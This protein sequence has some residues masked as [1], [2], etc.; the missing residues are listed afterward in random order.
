MKKLILLFGIFTLVFPL[1]AQAQKDAAEE[2]V[3]EA[4]TAF[5]TLDQSNLWTNNF[6]QEEIQTLPVGIKYTFG[7]GS[8][9]NIQA[10]IGV[11]KAVMYSDYAEITVF[12]RVRLPQTDAT[13]KPLELFFGADKVKLSYQG[14]IIGDIKLALLGDINIPFNAGKWLLTLKGGFDYKTGV[15]QGLTFATI[16]CDGIKNLAIAGSVEFSR[17]MIIPVEANGEIDEKKTTVT[18]SQ[19]TETGVYT[20]Q[21]P[22]RVRGDFQTIVEDWNDI[23]VDIDMPQSFVLAQKMNGVDYEDNFVLSI[24]H[25]VLDMS[26]LRNSPNVQ[27]PQYYTDNGLLLPSV[28]AW[29]G[30]YVQS[31]EVGMPKKFM[32]AATA[33]NGKRVT[34]GSNDLIID[35]YGV[36]GYFYADSLI[37]IAEGITNDQKSWAY[38][39]DHIAVN[40]AAN[41]LIGMD[42]NGSI[43]LPVSNSDSDGKKPLGLKYTGLF[44]GKEYL[45]AVKTDSVI[46]FN[47]WKAKGQLLPN[48]YVEMR[49]K[50]RQ[51]RPKAVLNGFLSIQASNKDTDGNGKE[52]KPLVEFSRIEFQGL[53]MQTEAPVFKVDYMG[54]KKGQNEENKVSNFPVTID[55]IGITANDYQANLYLGVAINLMDGSGGFSGRTKVS[56]LG[57]FQDDNN[58][59]QKW[60]FKGV[61][62]AAVDLS[63]KLGTVELNGS[64]KM[65]EDDP[66]YGDGFNARLNGK[67]GIIG[68][69]ACNAIFGNNGFRYWMVDASISGLNIGTGAFNLDGFTGGASYHMLRKAGAGSSSIAPSGLS[70]VPDAGTGLGVKAMVSMSIGNKNAIVGKAGFEIIFNNSGGVNQMG[71]YGEAQMM[72]GLSD[73]PG[74]NKLADLNDKLQ[75]ATKKIQQQIPE[76]IAK[77]VGE[78]YIGKNF[79][80]M[81]KEDYPSPSVGNGAIS[82][83]LGMQQDFV[84]NVFHAELEIYVNIGGVLVGR[85]PNYRA[86]HGVVH[87]APGEWYAYLGRPSDRAG[88]K[89]GIGPLSVNVGGYFMVGDRLEA[90]PPPP[91]VVAQILGVDAESLNYM[92]D[93]NALNS[94]RGFAFGIDFG[95]DTGDL[96]FL[97][98]YARFQ[99]GGGFDIMLRDY[100]GAI[101]S[102]TGKA[103]GIN[104]WYA[105]G[106]A[107][108]YL[109][110]ELGIQVKLFFVN[111]KVPIISAGAAVLLQAKAPNPIWMRGY[112]GGYYNVLGGLLKGNF[113]FKLTL[114][115]EC[116]FAEISPIGGIKIISDVS[117]DNNSETDVFA[118]P[119]ATFAMKVGENVI[120]PEDSGDKTYKITLDKFRILDPQ[121]KAIEGTVEWNENKDAAN[122]ISK[123]ILPPNTRLKAEV[124]VSFMEKVNGVFRP[125]TVDGKQAI[126]SETREFT[127]GGA[128]DVI[129]LQNIQYAYPVLDQKYFFTDEYKNGYI[130]LKRGQSYLFDDNQ[131]A[132]V[133][134]VTDKGGNSQSVAFS[135]NTADSRIDYLLPKMA[136]SNSYHLSIVSRLKNA[137]TK[138]DNGKQE[139]NYVAQETGDSENT[140]LVQQNKAQLLSQDGEIERLVYDFSTSQYKSLKDKAGSISVSGYNFGKIYSDVIYLTNKIKDHEDFDCV[141]L[142]GN[143]YTENFPTVT[144]EAVLDD[145][146]F[147]K[148]INP[149]LYGRQ[150]LGGAYS[151]K[152]RDKAEYGIPPAKALPLSGSYLTYTQYGI[153]KEWTRT[154][155]PFDYQLPYFYKL[156]WTDLQSQIINDYVRGILPGNSPVMQLLDAGYKFIRQGYYNVRLQ[157][158][159]PGGTKGTEAIM[160]YKNSIGL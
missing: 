128:P 137:N 62:L 133:L 51:F 17:E 58:Y 151:L 81:A 57:A 150:A 104:G 4:K 66:V 119:Q 131:W 69:I 78:N 155:F 149:V 122:F 127:T 24:K 96:R 95:L 110:G 117:P 55:E 74:M 25:A 39:V 8:G 142:T 21:V 38:S 50:E 32:T 109:Q 46:D 83:F 29:R 12:A 125:V 76:N 102:N 146:Y 14:G 124:Q 2:S 113:R 72:A 126:G 22:Y 52:K 100:A 115:E 130:R 37:Q 42:F 108:A 141:E 105:N 159:L 153:N 139:E 156:D 123:E 64:L 15:T 136:Q 43:V 103:P 26:D 93:E 154:T 85:G 53:T 70:Y 54:Y 61:D 11:T 114:G 3:S 5:Q 120:I 67:F 79:L 13:G 144:V 40:L 88:L 87:I 158:I 152:L 19:Q 16:N 71:F 89:A 92:R 129:P 35:G 7:K 68:P 18:V 118:I 44:S 111:M 63:A 47:L 147:T 30:V 20:K 91:P 148:D 140:M 60:V 41:N 90:S 59:K 135:Y 75:Q 23:L 94:G 132:S 6:S 9:S 145:D 160:K 77:G 33:K 65:M 49:V 157:Y 80:D 27:F 101:C 86:A 48:S 116:D 73:I 10:A 45:L 28:K 143:T 138:S 1:I 82:A 56:I 31:V 99:T 121:G 106:Q 84:N 112:V 134:I 34:F 107:Y 97:M 98:F 36:S